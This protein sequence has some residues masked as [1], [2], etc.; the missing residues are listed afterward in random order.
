MN[1]KALCFFFESGVNWKHREMQMTGG[2]EGGSSPLRQDGQSQGVLRGISSSKIDR[3]DVEML[4]IATDRPR[5]LLNI[6]EKMDISFVECLRRAS[7]LQRMGLL[8]KV[9]SVSEPAV[10]YLYVATKSGPDTIP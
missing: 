7:R 10:L 8:E 3:K 2:R 6:C 5:T 1:T 9:G 4:S